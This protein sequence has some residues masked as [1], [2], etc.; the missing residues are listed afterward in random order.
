MKS[1]PIEDS[2]SGAAHESD[3]SNPVFR[4]DWVWKSMS[5]PSRL[6]MRLVSMSQAVQRRLTNYERLL[7]AI[8]GISRAEPLFCDLPAG[9]VPQVLPLRVF[10]PDTVFPVLKAAGVPI[11]RFGEVL[12]PSMDRARHPAAIALSRE[13]FQLPCHQALNE[14]EID[15]LAECIRTALSGG[16]SMP[17]WQSS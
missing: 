8:S 6:I 11:I 5:M 12:W 16:S 10:E 1:Q 3:S 13:I 9:V 14:C 17:A 2:R 15:W 4:E 7:N